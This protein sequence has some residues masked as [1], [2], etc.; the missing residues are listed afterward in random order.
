MQAVHLK[1][2]FQVQ[3]GAGLQL[4]TFGFCW[5]NTNKSKLG[6]RRD[7][8]QTIFEQCLLPFGSESSIFTLAV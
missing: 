2:V 5:N 1:F 8:Q 4:S 6:V 7:Q 3:N